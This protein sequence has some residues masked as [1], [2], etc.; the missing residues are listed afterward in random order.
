M[1]CDNMNSEMRFFAAL[2]SAENWLVKS[3]TLW[4]RNEKRESLARF[5]YVAG[6]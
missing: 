3:D 5:I 1:A 4:L 6:K 2:R